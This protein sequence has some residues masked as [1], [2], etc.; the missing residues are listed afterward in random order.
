MK[1]ILTFIACLFFGATMICNAADREHTLKI[2][3]WAD[4]IDE[5]LLEEFKSWYKDQTGE[6]VEIIYQLFDVNEVMLSKI[7]LG[8]ED[9]DVVCPSDYIIERMLHLDLLL[10]IDRDFGNVPD[11]TVN[12]SPFMTEMV[13][14]MVTDKD[15]AKYVVP[16][17]WGTVGLLYNPKYVTPEQASS[18]D[19]LKTQ[20]S[21]ERFSLRM[22]SGMCSS[23][24]SLHFIKMR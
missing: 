22:H 20:S 21:R 12:V 14:N 19:C 8:H 7:E 3:N 15:P 13:N 2:Y 10:P 11:Y 17:M 18:W 5:D 6:E 24:L 4:Y 9:F 16:Y 23:L 1:K